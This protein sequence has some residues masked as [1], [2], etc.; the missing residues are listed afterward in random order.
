MPHSHTR[1]SVALNSAGYY[2]VQ[3]SMT[4]TIACPDQKTESAVIN[5]NGQLEQERA[6]VRDR[7]AASRFG[8]IGFHAYCEWVLN[9]GLPFD[10]EMSG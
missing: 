3:T 5:L 7:E 4:N 10:V 2:A 8:T 1:F 6:Q 9:G